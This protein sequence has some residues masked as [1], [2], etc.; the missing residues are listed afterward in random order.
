[1]DPAAVTKSAGVMEG[2]LKAAGFD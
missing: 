2:T 1:M